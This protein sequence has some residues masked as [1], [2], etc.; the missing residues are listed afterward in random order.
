M[1]YTERPAAACSLTAVSMATLGIDASMAASEQH[2]SCAANEP[3]DQPSKTRLC[4]T[5]RG[6]PSQNAAQHCQSLLHRNEVLLRMSLGRKSGAC[7]RPH[8]RSRSSF[9]CEDNLT[10]LAATVLPHGANPQCTPE[11]H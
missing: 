8:V 1:R 5:A 9:R 6:L 10:R 3:P 11:H 4:S 7:E 2:G